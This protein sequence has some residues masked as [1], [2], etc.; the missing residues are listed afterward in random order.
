MA[1]WCYETTVPDN[2]GSAVR[3]LR[4]HQ[5]C[6][7]RKPR[8]ALGQPSDGESRLDI[9]H[10]AIGTDELALPTNLVADRGWGGLR[11]ANAFLEAGLPGNS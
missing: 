9:G 3:R 10:S 2:L 11:V 8:A 4:L 1:E 7:L 6:C 5:E